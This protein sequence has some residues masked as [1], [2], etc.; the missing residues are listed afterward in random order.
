MGKKNQKC[1]DCA[2][3]KLVAK[4][5]CYK[6]GCSK[7]RSYYARHETNKWIANQRHRYLQYKDDKCAVCHKE[8]LLEVH[9]IIPQNKGGVDARFNLVTLC[10]DCH[11]T[12]S[13]YYSVIGWQ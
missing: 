6:K 12:I 8:Q 13:T 3:I 5:E 2:Q 11:Q 4:P 10:K 1:F 9:H 7:V